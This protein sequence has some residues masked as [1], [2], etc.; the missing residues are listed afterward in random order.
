[1]TIFRGVGGGGNSTT[2]SEITLLTAL[3]AEASAAATLAGLSSAASGVSAGNAATSAGTATTQA[4]NAAS[5]ASTASTQAGLATTNGAAQVTL[6][7]TQATNSAASAT[8][9]SSSASTA[10]TQATNASNSATAASGSAST[11]STQAS[12]ASTS[13][14]GASTSASNAATSA[15]TASTQ[16]SNAASSA[17]G[18]STSATNASNSA[19]AASGSASTASTQA[20]NASSSASAASTSASNAATSA[21]NAANSAASVPDDA[22]L[23]HKTGNETIAGIKTFSSAPSLAGAALTGTVAGGGNQINNVVIGATTPLAGSFTT[24]SATDTISTIKSSGAGGSI[25]SIKNSSDAAGDNVK[26]A[27]VDFLVGSD[28]G[29]SA[30][31]SYRI[32]SGAGYKTALAFLTN[33]SG[34]TQV[35]TEI[36]RIS[37]AGLAITG[38]LSATGALTSAAIK[39]VSG[40][41][42]IGTSTPASKLNVNNGFLQVDIGGIQTI[43]VGSTDSIIG[44]TDNNA[45]IQANTSKAIMFFAGGAERARIDS[46]G[47]LLVGYTSSN[48][49]YKLQV[50]S[51]IFATSSTVATS[52]GRYKE[53]VKPITGALALVQALNPVTFNW[54][55][56]PVHSFAEGTTTG[57]IAQEVQAA[58]AN[59]PYR[60][61]IVKSNH[62]TLV[63]AKY[64]TIQLSPA[65]EEVKDE[66]GNVT[67]PA[68]EAKT[69][70]KLI[71]A[72]VTEDFLGIAEGSLISILMAAVKELTAR[73]ES[74]EAK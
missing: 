48:G 37:E 29:T 61:S 33:P 34:A 65:V 4:S 55:P 40:N 31:R 12:N 15:S 47:N 73:L 62:C 54:K 58:L 17:S 59:T 35:P 72:A 25:V 38:A 13:A 68:S 44:G 57:F 53:N 71:S 63:P 27:G 39:E 7:T 16:A 28:N 14:S 64:E 49:S 41:V 2:D 60:D 30:I 66:N 23:V 26:Y 10:S 22:T 69:E 52:D 20:S 51:Q 36:M 43:R 9:A 21:T 18:A 56:H 74:L 32:N 3:A 24:V 8:N 67:T 19:T 42:G 70:Q 50:N 45:V 5:S 46:A 6:A 11:A 1:L